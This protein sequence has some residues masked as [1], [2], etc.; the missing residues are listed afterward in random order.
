LDR[1][2]LDAASPDQTLGS[3]N[4]E[5]TDRAQV[6]FISSGEAVLYTDDHAGNS[7]PIILE[8]CQLAVVPSSTSSWQV[9]APNAAEV[10]RIVPQPGSSANQR[11]A[12]YPE[13]LD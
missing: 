1:F 5:F 10:I 12:I 13:S 7:E 2:T 3:A 8:R 6:I 9:K 11:V 4:G